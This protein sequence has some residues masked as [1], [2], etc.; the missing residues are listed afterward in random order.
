LTS[1]GIEAKS[2]DEFIADAIN[3]NPALA[4][5]AIK[6]MRLRFNKPEKIPEVLLLDMERIG[7]TQS[8]D[9]LKDSVELV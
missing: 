7:L 6:K 1:Y 2:A 9:Q 3:L 5:T 8:A 4:I